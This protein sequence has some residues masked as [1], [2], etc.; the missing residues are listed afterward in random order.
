MQ[1]G[2]QSVSSVESLVDMDGLTDAG[3]VY[4]YF[5]IRKKKSSLNF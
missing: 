3:W 5:V 2:L 1:Q 4:L